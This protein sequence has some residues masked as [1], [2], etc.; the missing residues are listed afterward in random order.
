MAM[1]ELTRA[2]NRAEL[3]RSS[4]KLLH[5]MAARF[6]LEPN[7]SEKEAFKS[8]IYLFSRLYPVSFASLRRGVRSLTSASQ[9]GECAAE[10]QALL[11]KHP[12]QVRR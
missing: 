2:T 5:T 8:F 11:K 3:G 12:P 9:C 7:E 6:P 10:F 4:W 1:L